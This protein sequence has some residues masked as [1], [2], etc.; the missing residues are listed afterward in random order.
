MP[1][2]VYLDKE[3]N[4]PYAVYH[5]QGKLQAWVHPIGAPCVICSPT[6]KD[7]QRHSGKP[8]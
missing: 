4:K 3:T 2:Y 8:Q 7:E 1:S 6:S 5:R